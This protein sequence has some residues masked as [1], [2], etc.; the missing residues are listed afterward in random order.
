LEG[1][2][3]GGCVLKTQARDKR[4]WMVGGGGYDI[5]ICSAGSCVLDVWLR[6]DGM[7][8]VPL[9]YNAEGTFLPHSIY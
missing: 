5:G 2:R 8:Q 7:E 3:W 4:D 1:S 6:F 9:G